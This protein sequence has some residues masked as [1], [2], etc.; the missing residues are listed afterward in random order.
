MNTDHQPHVIA[1]ATAALL[2]IV[3]CA[4]AFAHSGSMRG[5]FVGGFAHPLF[6][7]D[8]AVAM[9]AVGLWGAFLGPPAT[10]LLPLGFPLVRGSGVWGGDRN[11]RRPAARCRN[12]DRTIRCRARHDGGACGKA[13]AVG[14]GAA[15]RRIRDLPRP[16]P[17][18]R[19][20]ARSRRRRVFRRLRSRNRI[21]PPHRHR[22]WSARAVAR[23][24]H[25]RAH[26]RRRHRVGRRGLPERAGMSGFVAGLLHPLV[27]PA[28]V[29]ALLALGLLIG[30]QMA[31]RQIVSLAAFVIGLAAGLTAIA[32]AVGQ[33]LAADVLLAVAFVS[34]A[35]A[36]MAR[37]LPAL[38]Y[39]LL[40]AI[41]GV[42]LGLDSPPET[43]SIAV[44]TAMLI[45]TGLGASLALAVIVAGTS[46]LFGVHEWIWA[47][48]GGRILGSW[49][50]ASAI[51]VLALR[52]ARGQLF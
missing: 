41:A 22:R 39:A 29:L 23:R 10:W 5:C 6:G 42:A 27:L 40:A 46:Y 7:P 8:H 32:F 19:T 45:G 15:R 25:R 17:W 38:A 37:P 30:Q 26:G 47:R 13:A 31:G 18:C 16:C 33:T 9:V 20:P 52:F 51:L 44:A 36:A 43:V 49:I 28:H 12:R 11:S 21:A 48:I 14:R 3:A 34:G 24:P 50:A 1:F 35:F 4:P 2:L